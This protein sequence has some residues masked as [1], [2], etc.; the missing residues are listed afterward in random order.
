MNKKNNFLPVIILALL[1]L[2]WGTSF[3]LIKQGLK[4]F[5][6]DVVGALRVTAASIF[7]LPVAFFKYQEVERGQIKKLFF[8]GLMGTFIPAFLF[9][10]AQTKLDSSVTGIL[11]SLSPLFTMVMGSVFF[12]Q[13]FKG[14]AIAGVLLGL[15]GTIVLM[16]AG[17]GWSING[18]NIYAFLV[19]V[20]CALYGTNLNY[21]KYQ[22]V[23]INSITLTA[24]ALVLIGPLA[25]VY[26][27]GFS[28]FM[29]KL[30][31]TPQAWRSMGL[32]VLLAFMSTALATMLFTWLVQKTS[33]LFAS[34]VTYIMPIV[35]VLWGLWDGESL[36]VGHFAGMALI[37]SGV[38]IANW[39]K[40]TAGNS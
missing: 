5:S 19:V 34:S 25:A 8:A 24:T 6:P 38:W 21:I 17:S 37:L 13:K 35:S 22:I 12:G 18:L 20:A 16:L 30:Q 28:D 4:V 40:T 36:H 9:A 23:G 39:K 32:V 11:N 33:P 26:L 15:I 14:L 27:F 10:T 1:S 29:L 7:L 31:T 2:I 3:I